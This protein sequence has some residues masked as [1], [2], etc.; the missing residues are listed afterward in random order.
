MIRLIVTSATY[1]QS[2][3][4]TPELLERDPSN[5]LLARGPRGRMPS[6]MIRDQALAASGLLTRTFGGPSVKTYQPAGI[7]EEATFGNKRYQPDKGE[8]LYR[9]SLYV[10]WRRIIGP[11]MFF[12]AANRQTCSI[13]GVT[14]NTPLHA[15]TT[16]NDITYVEA[17][18]TLAQRALEIGGTDT[19]RLAFAFRSVTSR[20]PTAAEAEIL[21]GALAKQRKVFA[22]DPAAATKLLKV[23]ESPRNEKLDPTEHAA[24]ASVCLTVFSLDE[25]LNK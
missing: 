4:V 17:A 22:A 7:W 10:Y 1:Q 9:R 11:T 25:A 5:R 18:R 8:A 15:L 23:G 12:D 24:L 2:A 6:W 16:L 13:K 14:T 21:A 3:K 19:D 20:R